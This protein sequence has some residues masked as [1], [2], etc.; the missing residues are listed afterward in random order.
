MMERGQIYSYDKVLV[1]GKGKG[2]YRCYVVPLEWT[3]GILGDA[4]CMRPL[5]VIEL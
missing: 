4:H 3:M 1:V 5:I 2:F